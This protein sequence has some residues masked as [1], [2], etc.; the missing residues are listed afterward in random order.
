MSKSNEAPKLG[1]LIR[2]RRTRAMALVIRVSGIYLL[3]R[4]FD[5]SVDW[6]K[7]EDY[8]VINSTS[9]A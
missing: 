4:W 1:D 6:T 3:V 8:E 7:A 2:H 9:A 5:E